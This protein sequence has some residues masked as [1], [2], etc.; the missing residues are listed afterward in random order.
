M[1]LQYYDKGYAYI[2][3]QLLGES[4]G[5][6]IEYQ[7]EP[8]PVSTLVKD[9]AGVTPVPKSAMVSIDSFVPARGLEVDVIKSW[10]ETSVITIKLQ[11]GGSGKSMQADGFVLPPSI[12]FSA[13]D[14][15]KLSFRVHCEAV[16]FT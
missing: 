14:S 16:A 15:T 7:G 13:T 1:S 10:L 6:S 5:G 9:F 2:D 8:I 12:S 11:F 3:G 4:S